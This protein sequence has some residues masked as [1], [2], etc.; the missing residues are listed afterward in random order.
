MHLLGKNSILKTHYEILSVKEDASYEEIRAAYKSAILTCHPDKSHR[1]EA[2]DHPS[3]PQEKFMNVQKAWE[4][5][6]DSVTRST[7][8]H[9][10]KSSR[11]DNE[12]AAEDISLEEMTMEDVG[13][14]LEFFYQCRCGDYYAIDSTELEEMGYSLDRVTNE[15]LLNRPGHLPMS[16]ILPCGSC[17]L[18]I[19]LMIN[20]HC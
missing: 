11:H 9:E 15:V 8:S 12:T 2:S 3:E 18:K 19:R 5:L 10:L 7:Y 6:S 16:V 20:S 14:V 1:A 4:I 13:Q 17:S